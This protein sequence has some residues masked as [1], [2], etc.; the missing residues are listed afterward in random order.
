M[1]CSFQV[2]RHLEEHHGVEPPTAQG[3]YPMLSHDEH[4]RPTLDFLL[5]QRQDWW[6]AGMDAGSMAVTALVYDRFHRQEVGGHELSCPT[7]RR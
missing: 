2:R 7:Q 5:S 1:L 4:L 6:V 3:E